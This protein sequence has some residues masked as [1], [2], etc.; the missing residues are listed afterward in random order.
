MGEPQCRFCHESTEPLIS[1]CRCDG[2]MKYIHRSC[3]LR[4]ATMSGAINYSR[5]ICSVCLT[6]Y[7][8]PEVQLE[9]FF[10]GHYP[11]DMIFYNH[12]TVYIV[13]NYISL[14]YG[15]HTHDRI[16]QRVSMAQVYIFT[17]YAAL[18][19][20]FIRIKN[21][22]L[23]RAYALQKRLHLYALLHL[24][25]SYMVYTQKNGLMS[26]AAMLSHATVWTGHIE[27]LRLVNEAV[28]QQE[29]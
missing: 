15:M 21:L 7:T 1:P 9:S 16:S 26:I 10:T 3:V 23:Y 17:L 2:S 8:L 5:M 6:P 13:I 19:L 29:S 12:N 4:W 14:I 25:I 11:V 24:Y 22:D 20:F 28:V 18:I 27:T